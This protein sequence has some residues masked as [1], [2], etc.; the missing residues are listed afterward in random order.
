[1]QQPPTPRRPHRRTRPPGET[2]HPIAYKHGTLTMY[3]DYACRC[4]ACQQAWRERTYE[5]AKEQRG[6]Y[7]D[8]G[9]ADILEYGEDTELT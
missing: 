5:K 1:M 2:K 9:W 6:F 8:Q 4:T 3:W 7:D